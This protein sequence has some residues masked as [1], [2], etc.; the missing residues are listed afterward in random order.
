MCFVEFKD[1][2]SKH[3]HFHFLKQ[4]PTQIGEI[5]KS[6]LELRNNFCAKYKTL[7]TLNLHSRKT[8]TKYET[9]VIMYAGP[10]VERCLPPRPTLPSR[11]PETEMSPLSAGHPISSV[12]GFLSSEK[13]SV[14][15][16]GL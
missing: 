11:L 10:M 8:L 9:A 7:T 6:N 16:T 12:S 13:H 15:Q 3:H 1:K 4:L 2:C 5:E 14:L